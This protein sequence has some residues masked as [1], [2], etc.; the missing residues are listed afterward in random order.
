MEHEEPW[1][2]DGDG[3]QNITLDNNNNN[4]DDEEEED[5][6][7][8]DLFADKCS[9]FKITFNNNITIN[10]KGINAKYPMFLQSTGMTLWKSS[11]VLCS[12]L[13]DNPTVVSGKNVIELG[14]G[15]GLAGIIAYK[16]GAEKVLLTDGDTDTLDNMRDNVSANS[17]RTNDDNDDCG[18]GGDTM[19]DDVQEESILCK[20]LRWGQN[21]ADFR[22]KW[23][24][25][26]FD[27]VMVRISLFPSLFIYILYCLHCR[28]LKIQLLLQFM[29]QK[30][31]SDIIYVKEYVKVLFQTVSLLLSSKPGSIFLV[32]HMKRNP[33]LNFDY[34]YACAKECGFDWTSPE[35]ES[36]EGI[37]I[38]FQ[39][40]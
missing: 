6:G 22:E 11:K 26:G 35:G 17:S 3:N 5:Y 18:G 19:G 40:S 36:E 9:E 21:V 23:N 13:C 8:S 20:Q 12:F 27:V 16:L 14:A 24:P 10:L 37:Y 2:E 1:I 38:F 34:I 15:L 31:G 25:E 29:I 30:K 33:T 32:S 28:I 39:R 7:G 4:D